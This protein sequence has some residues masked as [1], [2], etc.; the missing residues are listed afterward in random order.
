V[1]QPEGFERKGSRDKVYKLNKA[2]YVLRQA[3]RAWNNKLNHILGELQFIKCSKEPTVYQ[4][5]VQEYLLIVAVYVDDLFVTG[6]SLEVINNFKAEMSSR[7]DMSD[8]G[9]LSYYLGIE[10]IQHNEGIMLNQT[11]YALKILEEAGMQDCNMV[12]TPMENGLQLSKSEHEKNVDATTFRKNVGCFRYLL[13][14]RPDLSY[15]VGCFSRYMQSP[16][17]SHAATMKQ[18]LRYLKGTTTLGLIF[19][20]CTSIPRLVGYSDSSHNVDQDDSKSTAGHIVYLRESPISWCSQKQETVALCSCEAEFMGGTEAAKQA[21]WLQDV[22]SEIT[23]TACGKVI[24]RLDNK[25]AI[26]LTKNPLFHGRSKH[27][28]RLYHFIRE[29]V[30]NGQVEVEH[31]PDNEQKADILTKP[32]GRIKFKEMRSLIG[33]QDVSEDHFKIKGENVGLK[34]KEK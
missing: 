8:L 26:A 5:E 2:L 14:T 29:C 1:C 6:T 15:S 33:V 3:P 34:L 10:V 23:E 25:S 12:H 7:F 16:R 22:L 24:I 11:R 31:V 21:I 4:R 30:E 20:R 27:I 9:K 17:E 28:Q 19:K 13:H 18:C 32:L